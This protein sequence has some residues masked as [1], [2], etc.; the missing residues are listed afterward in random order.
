MKTLSILDHMRAILIGRT[1]YWFN[2]L[3]GQTYSGVVTDIEGEK[4]L[5]RCDRDNK[6]RSKNMNE[7][8]L[9]KYEPIIF[10]DDNH[11]KP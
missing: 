10:N 2:E 5:I 6:I 11:V 9:G 4:L 1:V 3:H 7:C 8:K